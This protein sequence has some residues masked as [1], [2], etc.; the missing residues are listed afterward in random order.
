M[1]GIPSFAARCRRAATRSVAPKRQRRSAG[2]DP[3]EGSD[4]RILLWDVYVWAIPSCAARSRPAF[5]RNKQRRSVG[6][7]PRGSFPAR[8]LRQR[9]RVRARTERPDEKAPPIFLSDTAAE[10]ASIELEAHFADTMLK[11][12]ERIPHKR[13]IPG[14]SYQ[15]PLIWS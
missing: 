11:V 15:R 9:H 7:D 4:H 1:A 13:K 12:A 10:A 14:G 3:R 8:V 2:C 6:C 5:A